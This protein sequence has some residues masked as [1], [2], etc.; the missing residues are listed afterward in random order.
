MMKY[1]ITINDK[2][3]E[4]EVMDSAGEK[5]TNNSQQSDRTTTTS[6]LLKAPMPG[7]I[8]DI[9]INPGD[10]AKRG[11]TLFILEAMKMENEISAP[12]DGIIKE[13]QVVKGAS[14]STN[15]VLAVIEW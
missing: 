11:D 12:R 15:D 5:A 7:T 8:I 13:I 6:E 9:K 3:Y 14:V 2:K 1:T 10:S 4:V